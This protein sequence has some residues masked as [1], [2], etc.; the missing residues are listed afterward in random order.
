M[1]IV[2]DGV[3]FIA[4]ALCSNE[5]RPS[6]VDHSGLRSAVMACYA[7]FGFFWIFVWGSCSNRDF[8]AILTASA[9]VQCLGF[10]LLCVKVQGRKSCAGLSSKSLTL[11]FL[12]FVTR[13]TSTSM[14][15]GYLPIDSSGDF[16]Y[17]IMDFMSLLFVMNLLYCC[18][19]THSHSFQEEHDTCPLMP[20]LVPCVICALCIHGNFNK[21]LFFDIIWALSTNI[22]TF[23]LVPQL[24]MLAKMGGKVD[25][26]TAHF[27]VCI[28]IS[29]ILAFTFW[30]WTGA[31][32]EKRGPNLAAKLI[33][34]MQCF[35]LLLCADFMFYYFQGWM[36]G[37]GVVL[38]ENTDGDTMTM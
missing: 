28:V 17:Q 3:D 1:S 19:K 30:H 25:G 32:L 37:V 26:I 8:S 4:R 14:K 20:L 15:N 13:L 7:V 16:M 9:C 2:A 36:G 33:K 34:G 5:S 31:E 18:H 11:F 38:P 6:G 35:K 10:L 24:W 29:N 22:E 21:N 12:H 23:V 27:V